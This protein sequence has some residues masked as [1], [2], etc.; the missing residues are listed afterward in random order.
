MEDYLVVKEK[1]K[2]KREEREREREEK[3][4]ITIWLAECNR[5]RQTG[6]NKLIAKCWFVDYGF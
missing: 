1:K 3:R 6:T 5:N 2:K 4:G